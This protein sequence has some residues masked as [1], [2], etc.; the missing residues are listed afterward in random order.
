S[1]GNP[2][3]SA[4]GVKKEYEPQK[5]LESDPP[6]PL[7][8]HVKNWLDCIRTGAKPNADIELGY[9]HG[10]AVVM[11]DLSWNVNRKVTFDPKTR[12]LRLA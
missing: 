3:M 9:K 6:S 5:L 12:E 4:E 8:L 1:P 10:I 7:E 2:V 11:G